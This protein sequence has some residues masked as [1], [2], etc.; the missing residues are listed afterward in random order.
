MGSTGRER[1]EEKYSFEQLLP[2][3]MAIYTKVAQDTGNQR[4]LC[5]LL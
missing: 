4:V 1:V 2:N 5:A 3:L